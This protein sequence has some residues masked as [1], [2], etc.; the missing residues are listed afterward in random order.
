MVKEKTI[1]SPAESV[2]DANLVTQGTVSKEDEAKQKSYDK[3]FNKFI[4]EFEALQKKYDIKLLQIPAKLI[5]YDQK[6]Y[7][8]SK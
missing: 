7:K 8:E 1:S 6:E 4:K 5:Y 3:R 2:L